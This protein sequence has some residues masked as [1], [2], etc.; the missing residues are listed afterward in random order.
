MF[1]IV[2]NSYRTSRIVT[3]F[4]T[5]AFSRS[6][7][8]SDG[9]ILLMG[10]Q[11]HTLGPRDDVHCFDPSN[12]RT[13]LHATTLQPMPFK[14][15][16]FSVCSHD[17]HVYVM[18]GKNADSQVVNSCERYDVTRDKWVLLEPAIKKRY[19]ASASFVKETAKIYLFGGRTDYNAEMVV[20]VEE[21]SVALNSWTLLKIAGPDEWM[22][23]EV[24]A[25]VQ[26]ATDRILVFGGSD[27]QI[28]D[29]KQ[30]YVFTPSEL[31]MVKTQ[32][33]KKAQVFVN[34]PYVN[35]NYVYV[36]GNEYYVKSRNIHRF[37]IKS[38][39]WDIVK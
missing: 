1:N 10:G 28:E 25:S 7:T 27:L 6:L 35:G 4:K 34:A 37:S 22:P 15:Y 12:A 23:V 9:R 39:Q 3:T 26:I 8:L 5:A 36:P 38:M 11:D 19:A 16:D 17:Q 2:D 18:C 33:L 30:S 24:C 14:K 20:E 13:E 31:K 32:P 21:Y 29:S